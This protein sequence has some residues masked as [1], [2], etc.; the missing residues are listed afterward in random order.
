[1]AWFFG[2]FLAIIATA[3]TIWMFSIEASTKIQP[4]YPLNQ[5]MR[6]LPPLIDRYNL[7]YHELLKLLLDFQEHFPLRNGVVFFLF[8][9]FLFIFYF[10]QSPPLPAAY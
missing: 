1:M 4:Y 6:Q 8:F 3:I 10:L 2:G 5:L 7:L 9:I